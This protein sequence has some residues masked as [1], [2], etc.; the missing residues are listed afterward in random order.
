M[1]AGYLEYTF[2]R[3]YNVFHISKL[4]LTYLCQAEIDKTL[5]TE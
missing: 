2:R 5:R 3:K 4:L 1:L